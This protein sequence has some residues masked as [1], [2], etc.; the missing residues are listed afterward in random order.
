MLS[1]TEV[2]VGCICIQV[3]SYNA[4]SSPIMHGS[5]TKATFRTDNVT[6]TL[7]TPD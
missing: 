2:L 7:H 5:K 6:L 3:F 4:T 1:L